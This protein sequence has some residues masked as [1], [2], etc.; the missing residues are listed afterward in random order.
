MRAIIIAII[1]VAPVFSASMAALPRTNSITIDGDLSDFDRSAPVRMNERTNVALEMA[2]GA[3]RG[4]NDLS[5]E[6]CV[7]YDD[8][9]LYIGCIVRDT[10]R[11]HKHRTGAYFDG[12]GVE[13]FLSSRYLVNRTNAA[14]VPGDFQIYLL[15]PTAPGE[16]LLVYKARGGGSVPVLTLFGITA[17]SKEH[18]DH[19]TMEIR[20]PL[21]LVSAGVVHDIGINVAVDDADEDGYRK[22]QLSI[23]GSSK[24][25]VS[26]RYLLPLSF[27]GF[28][29]RPLR[30]KFPMPLAAAFI[31]GFVL[32]VGYCIA[33]ERIVALPFRSKV[34]AAVISIG[35]LVL[36]TVLYG[37]VF[38]VLEFQRGMLVSRIQEIDRGVVS[39]AKAF[40]EGKMDSDDIARRMYAAVTGG[41]QS[42]FFP[43]YSVPLAPE[44][45][46]ITSRQGTP[47][48][49]E[50]MIPN[51]SSIAQGIAPVRA[52]GVRLI[53][54]GT[55]AYPTV[56]EIAPAYRLSFLSSAGRRFD[57]VL[58]NGVNLFL[59]QYR[60][61]NRT[62]ISGDA[63]EGL[64][65]INT[66][67]KKVVSL[68]GE[69]ALDFGGTAD[70]VRIEGSNMLPAA[71]AMVRAVTFVDTIRAVNHPGPF[72]MVST[73]PLNHSWQGTVYYRYYPLIQHIAGF[74]E[75]KSVRYPVSMHMD[76][77][78]VQYSGS[79]DSMSHSAIR[80][81][82]MIARIDVRYADGT[83]ESIPIID[84]LS[85]SSGSD[86]FGHGF[87]PH[88]ISEVSRR[89]TGLSGLVSHEHELIVPVRPE[90]QTAD[91]IVT[92]KESSAQF[93]PFGVTAIRRIPGPASNISLRAHDLNILSHAV[94]FVSV[95]GACIGASNASEEA[96]AAVRSFNIRHRQHDADYT[97]ERVMSTAFGDVIAS[98]VEYGDGTSSVVL[99]HVLPRKD[100]FVLSFIR[101]LIFVAL[102]FA[103][104]SLIL[105]AVHRIIEA[106]HL[107][108]KMLAV[109]V[110]LAV[111]PLIAGVILFL[112]VYNQSAVHDMIMSR[113]SAA[114][115]FI[116]TDI[117]D[118]LTALAKASARRCDALIAHGDPGSSDDAYYLMHDVKGDRSMS[119]TYS[120]GTPERF[121]I[122]ESLRLLKRSGPLMNSVFGFC[123]AWT[124]VRV[125][126]D[127]V[128]SVT[129]FRDIDASVLEHWN[130]RTLSLL[131]LHF[132]NGYQAAP[133]AVPYNIRVHTEAGDV[134]RESGERDIGGARY[135]VRAFPVEN[136]MME[137]QLLIGIAVNVDHLSATRLIIMM[138]GVLFAAIFG[139][140][141]FVIA[142]WFSRR[143]A[144]AVLAVA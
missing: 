75:M 140:L 53:I 144:G 4:T 5:A 26:A 135:Y 16:K 3:W 108:V 25:Y 50:A 80:F 40:F 92:I 85:Y 21:H 36:C 132:P 52:T 136:E 30:F 48:R 59:G 13:L 18:G 105:I 71:G 103:L 15:P 143:I 95:N 112:V 93:T 10:M 89:A 35:A 90:K 70:I 11:R 121:I 77:V 2:P 91:V 56:K 119:L 74:P 29:W 32:Y 99:L 114:E 34:K 63:K 38:F 1:A 129:A 123:L 54:N 134:T 58:T 14:S 23:N 117:S 51:T 42:A 61:Q 57:L 67:S 8:E 20:V 24:A 81:A 69:Y 111:M 133:F 124:T 73:S 49:F 7:N 6:V 9:Y 118:R 19:Y 55:S 17:A 94:P 46:V 102:F 41:T 82:G 87:P 127:R 131:S 142:R 28:F 98:P 76:E 78:R 88:F 109:T 120:K 113:T 125:V 101:V 128:V 65:L 83:V 68:I 106:R 107:S 138:G 86:L 45:P 12:D 60:L 130:K 100:A 72:V 104:I 96:T 62:N 116:R 64:L 22:T 137:P 37:A 43:Y 122:P 141:A 66:D 27:K 31:I 115:N 47:F 44:L 79:R 97:A 110:S 84:G 39:N 126:G 139:A 33:L